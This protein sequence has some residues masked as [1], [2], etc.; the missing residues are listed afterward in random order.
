MLT[1][2]KSHFMKGDIR[3]LTLRGHKAKEQKIG[4][5]N[6]LLRK[7]SRTYLI[8]RERNRQKDGYHF[9]AIVKVVK[10]PKKTWYRKGV[11]MN[12]KRV[13]YLVPK[14]NTFSKQQMQDNVAGLS[15]E[16]SKRVLT[17]MSKCNVDDYIQRQEQVY[18]VR[19]VDI[20][21]VLH[22]MAKEMEMPCQYTDYIWSK[23]GKQCKLKEG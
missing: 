6:D 3:F 14:P 5:V 8:V 13:G 16:D 10:V 22:Y 9:H 17:E 21:R 4:Y 11:H 12:L 19:D 18:V 15:F 7:I 1:E 20:D 23:Q 2:V